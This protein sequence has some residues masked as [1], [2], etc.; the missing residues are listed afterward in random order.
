MIEVRRK[1]WEEAFVKTSL[2]TFRLST[3]GKPSRGNARWRT[4]LG[5]AKE[6]HHHF[7]KI[8]PFFGRNYTFSRNCTLPLFSLHPEVVRP[9]VPTRSKRR[10]LDILLQL[11]YN[12]FW[13]SKALPS[14]T[15]LDSEIDRFHIT[16]FQ[17]RDEAPCRPFSP[18]TTL[19]ECGRLVS[20]K[21]GIYIAD[22]EYSQ[23]EVVENVFDVD[24]VLDC[25]YGYTFT[26]STFPKESLKCDCGDSQCWVVKYEKAPSA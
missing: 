11:C 1:F 13:L 2:Y 25:G 16:S 15:L 19:T 7:Q 9:S 23:E 3:L 5:E 21:A 10:R 12:V 8:S 14:P 4:F 26:P 17:G 18:L 24:I 6:K 20:G 22:V